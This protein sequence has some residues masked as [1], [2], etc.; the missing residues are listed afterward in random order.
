MLSKD[1]ISILKKLTQF[2]YKMNHMV[3]SYLSDAAKEA[4]SE[5]D[6]Y[7]LSII[8]GT[9]SMGYNANDGTYCPMMV[10]AD[11]RRTFAVED[12]DEKAIDVLKEAILVIS[13]AWMRAQLGEIVWIKSKERSYLEIAVT[14]FV[15][16]FDSLF[17]EENWV[18]CFNMIQRAYK[19]AVRQGKNSD[20]FLKVKEAIG[21]ALKKMDGKDPLFLSLSL[22]ELDYKNADTE[23][24]STYL[25]FAA[26]IFERHFSEGQ[27]NIH[28][29][30]ASFELYC[31]ILKKLKRDNDILTVM[32]QMAQYYEARAD[33]E[34]ESGAVGAYRAISLLQKACKQYRRLT[35][36]EKLLQIRKRIA[37]L[38][39]VSMENMASIPYEFDP[40]PIFQSVTSLFEGLSLQEMIIQLGRAT[41][42]YNKENIKKEVLKNQHE[43]LSSSLFTQNILDS[44]GHIVEIIPPLD[45]QD[46]EG[47][48]DVLY[49]HM[50]KYITETRSL[51]ET[52]SLTYAFR[53]LQSAETISLDDLDFLVDDNQIIPNSRKDIVKFGLYLGLTGKFYA[54]MHILLPQTEHIIRNLVDICGDTT[55]FLG[56]DGCEEYKPLSKLLQSEKL[57]ECYNENIL[58]TFQT[59]LDARGGPNLRNLNAHGL[60]EPEVGNSGIAL[61]F[62]SF[63]IKF[64]SLYSEKAS[65]ILINLAKKEKETLHKEE[66]NQND[67]SVP[68]DP[69]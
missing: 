63:L 4:T 52:I 2:E 7:I 27:E 32:V 54:A 66:G 8:G 10:L 51:G 3:S 45:L 19:L 49:K 21:Q 37:E 25:T 35:D 9:L 1:V 56:E 23:E 26:K 5:E 22:I 38:Q 46:P 64:L 34:M 14:E 31:T 17:D 39:K 59:L 41:Q 65:E 44:N 68:S 62:L 29:V 67:E 28:L 42:T 15:K 12:I 60:L 24:L 16:E 47:D 69:S 36:K 20:M 53:I 50:V 33:I 55:S 40:T 30:E 57:L 6:K 43:F 11:G 13:P 48:P 58:F 61:C 18:N